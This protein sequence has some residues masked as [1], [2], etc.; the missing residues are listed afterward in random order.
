LLSESPGHNLASA[1]YE[2]ANSCNLS[3]IIW[4]LLQYQLVLGQLA[5]VELIVEGEDLGYGVEN[6]ADSSDESLGTTMRNIND[7]RRTF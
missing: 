6:P 4:L 5:P 7:W 3:D 2:V 1:I